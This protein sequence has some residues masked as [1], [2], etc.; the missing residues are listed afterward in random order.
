VDHGI[1]FSLA[2][3]LGFTIDFIFREFISFNFYRS[4]SP[5][6]QNQN[7]FH[8]MVFCINSEGT[9][10]RDSNF[11]KH[12]SIDYIIF[13]LIYV[14]QTLR[15]FVYSIEL[16]SCNRTD[17]QHKWGCCFGGARGFGSGFFLWC[18][19]TFYLL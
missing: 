12:C 18:S 13:F 15:E 14:I 1:A 9:W 3:E 4:H 2:C 6:T 11:E 8:Q 19:A 17:S 5:K 7:S 10:N 16:D